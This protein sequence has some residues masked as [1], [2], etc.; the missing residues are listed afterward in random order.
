[1]SIVFCCCIYVKYTLAQIIFYELQF[2]FKIGI[3]KI[4]YIVKNKFDATIIRTNK[5][6][7]YT[8]NLQFQDTK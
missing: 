8:V 1:M 2:I 5:W 6:D 3:F 4:F 7:Y